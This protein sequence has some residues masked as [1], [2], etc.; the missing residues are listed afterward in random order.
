MVRN[1]LNATYIIITKIFI[2]QWSVY[3]CKSLVTSMPHSDPIVNMGI[4][5]HVIMIRT[6]A[7]AL[8]YLPHLVHLLSPRLPELLEIGSPISLPV[9]NNFVIG[10]VTIV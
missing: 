3:G 4:I 10:I 5:V 6:Y 2:D 7:H 8:Y 1:R 9:M